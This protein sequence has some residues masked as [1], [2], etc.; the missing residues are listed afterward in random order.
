VLPGLDVNEHGATDRG[1]NIVGSQAAQL[2]L[3]AV[4]LVKHLGHFS[5][6]GL[7]SYSVITNQVTAVVSF[8][9]Y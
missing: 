4:C 7:P 9:A 2:M 5:F 6:K 1:C 8:S 3:A